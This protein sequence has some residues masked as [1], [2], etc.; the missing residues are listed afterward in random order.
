MRYALLSAAIAAAALAG[1][2]HAYDYD[3]WPTHYTFG[4][5]TDLGLVLVYRYDLNDFSDDR[6]PDG[7]NAFEDS[8]TN[9]RKE[10]G[11]S[12]RK[13]GLYDAIIDYEYQGKTW[14]DTNVRFYSKAFFGEDYGA[15]RFGYSKTPVS[16]EGNTST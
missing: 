4:D 1:P 15:F 13:K 14:L 8:S 7:S 6:K 16:F 2:A 3:D 12:L 10:L 5:G 9:R 11:L